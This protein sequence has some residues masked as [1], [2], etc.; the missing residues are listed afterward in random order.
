MNKE[1]NYRTLLKMRGKGQNGQEVP[2]I[3]S[4]I[5]DGF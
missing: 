1:G 5:S 3:F 4:E 2:G